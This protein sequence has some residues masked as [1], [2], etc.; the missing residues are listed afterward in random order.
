MD[1]DDAR[2]R[3]ELR[4][5]LEEFSSFVTSKLAVERP[6]PGPAVDQFFAAAQEL[7]RAL[8]RGDEISQEFLEQWAGFKEYVCNCDQFQNIFERID[9]FCTSTVERSKDILLAQRI[10]SPKKGKLVEDLLSVGND[11]REW[12]ELKPIIRDYQRYMEYFDAID[13]CR[14]KV[15]RVQRRPFFQYP[16]VPV[17]KNAIR[18]WP[19]DNEQRKS[20]PES[21]PKSEPESKPEASV[22]S[23]RCEIK[24]LLRIAFGENGQGPG[25]V[26]QLVTASGC[27]DDQACLTDEIIGE[28]MRLVHS[29]SS[30]LEG[31]KNDVNK[32]LDE[33]LQ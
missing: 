14:W 8:F 6:Q 10:L 13:E 1:L 32:V 15:G 7:L 18:L 28:L 21:T 12:K 31:F 25:L 27:G 11:C 4:N 17:V 30:D 33:L 16:E 22:E 26:S 20:E 2:A 3:S 23:L 19:Q 24:E 9:D 29:S 5:K